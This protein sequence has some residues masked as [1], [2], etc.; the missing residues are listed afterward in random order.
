MC[1]E[2]ESDN[3]PM[4]HFGTLLGTFVINFFDLCVCMCVCV[5]VCMCVCAFVFVYVCVNV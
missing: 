5:C 2:R 4:G 3:V 1:V